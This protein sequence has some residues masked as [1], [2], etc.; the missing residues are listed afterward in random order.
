PGRAGDER[1]ASHAAGR[2]AGVDEGGPAGAR[3]VDREVA[4]G[5]RLVHGGDV[6]QETEVRSEEMLLGGELVQTRHS[7]I[8]NAMDGMSE[9]GHAPA[10]TTAFVDGRFRDP[11]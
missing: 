4:S 10:G 2:D 8:L 11:P 5:R 1:E 7:G 6:L 3:A 9:T